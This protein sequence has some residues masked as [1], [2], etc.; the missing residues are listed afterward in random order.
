[1]DLNPTVETFDYASLVDIFVIFDVVGH[2]VELLDDIA[3][4]HHQNGL[5]LLPAVVLENQLAAFDV[6]CAIL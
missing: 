4:L 6:R 1:M 3:L 5:G 2:C